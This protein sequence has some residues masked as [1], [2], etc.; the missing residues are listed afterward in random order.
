MLPPVLTE[1]FALVGCVAGLAATGWYLSQGRRLHREERARLEVEFSARSLIDSVAKAGDWTPVPRESWEAGQLAARW[2]A[3]ELQW[4]AGEM[5]AK[6]KIT[7]CG[8]A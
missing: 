1:V 5:T 4:N 7:G 2:G 3:I 8:I 6:A